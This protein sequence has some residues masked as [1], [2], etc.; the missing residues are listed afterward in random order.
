MRKTT[1]GFIDFLEKYEEEAITFIQKNE[2]LEGYFLGFSGGKDSCVLK[3]LTKRSGVKFQTYYSVTGID[4]PEV[5]KF[6]KRNH[7]DV[8]WKNLKNHFMN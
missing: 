7:S 5:V 8:I 4:P 3:D 2:P 1:K 6:I